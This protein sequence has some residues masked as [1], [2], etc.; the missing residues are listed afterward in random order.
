MKF[1]RNATNEPKIQGKPMI[2]GNDFTCDL[3]QSES[4]IYAPQKH[5]IRLFHMLYEYQWYSLVRV[6]RTLVSR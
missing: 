2:E 5:K 1:K 6:T 3:S 4:I